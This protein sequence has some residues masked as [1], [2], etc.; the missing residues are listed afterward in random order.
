MQ[1]TIGNSIKISLFGESH[2][3]AIGVVIDG[4]APGLEIDRDFIKYQLEKRKPKGKISTKRCELDEF[5]IISGVFNGYTTGTP[6]TIIIENTDQK[7]KDYEKTKNIMRPSHGDYT[8][9]IKYLGYNDYRGGGHFSGRI[10]APLVAAGAIFI[11]ILR[12]KG[13]DIGTH[14]L[15]C[16]DY[17]EKEFSQDEDELRKEVR[18]V[19]QKYFPT[20]TEIAQEK[21]QQMI[22]T[23]GANSDSIGGILETAVVGV[24]AG[25]G[26]PY[27][28]SVE[29]I[30]SHLI[31]SIPGVKGVEFGA[32]FKITELYGSES[33]DSYYYKDEEVKTRT[34]NNGGING[35]ITNS[36]PI[37]MKVAIKA[38]PSI[39]KEQESIDIGKK[40]SVKI[41]IGGRHDPAII[42]R[43]RVVVDSLTAFGLLDMMCMRYGYMWMTDNEKK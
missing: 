30:L 31:F 33:N 20:L 32:G 2:G 27:F 4:L 5:K 19:S 6:L 25:I 22:E 9:N 39:Y 42:H 43:A 3:E 7:S 10:T 21:M 29:S 24:Q 18:D 38:T 34:N 28:N 40:E 1:S 17:K 8:G 16:K 11:N 13:I 15:K 35:G 23:A 14:I 26:E 36:M 41:Q 37:I 12:L